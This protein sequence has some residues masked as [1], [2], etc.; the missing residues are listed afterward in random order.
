MYSASAR[1]GECILELQSSSSTPPANLPD[2]YVFQS[3]RIKLDLG[4]RIWP[5]TTPCFGYKG[6]VE[7]VVYV[8]TLAHVK[9]ITVVVRFDH[10]SPVFNKLIIFSFS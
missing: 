1:D 9:A 5:V 8:T 7:G 6:T 2:Q 10:N 3:H 4:E